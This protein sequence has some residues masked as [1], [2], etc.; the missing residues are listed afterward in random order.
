MMINKKNAVLFISL[1]CLSFSVKAAGQTDIE[2]LVRTGTV[3][4]IKKTLREHSYLIDHTSRDKRDSLLMTAL[5]SGRTRDIIGL[6]LDAGIDP[7]RKNRTGQ[8]ALMY[9]CQFSDDPAVIRDVL[10][11]GTLFNFQRKNR[12]LVRD[13]DGKTAFDYAGSKKAVLEILSQYAGRPVGTGGKNAAAADPT[14]PAAAP[15]PVP[16]P[17]PQ[18][19]GPDAAAVE[20][21][22][23]VPKAVGNTSPSGPEQPD[24]TDHT[25]GISPYQPVYLF[26]PDYSYGTVAPVPDS[27]DTAA[28]DKTDKTVQK[29][30]ADGYTALMAAARKADTGTVKQLLGR[31]ADVN[32]QD[33]DGWTALMYAVRFTESAETVGLLVSGGADTKITNRYGITPLMLASVFSDNPEIIGKLLKN[34]KMTNDEVRSA[35]ILSITAQRPEKLVSVFIGNGMPVNQL[36]PDKTPLMYA[37]ETGTDTHLILLL[38]KAGARTDIRTSDGKTAFDFAAANSNLRRDDVYWLLNRKN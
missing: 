9:A 6:L 1:V 25:E 23:S 15:M 12:I 24:N 26:D 29:E 38:L 5:E 16:S 14:V 33:R 27:I 2:R 22:S 20:T 31:G 10:L 36:Y 21:G 8:T 13:R 37:A 30:D 4:E 11:S 19:R 18:T 7:V 3:D 32:A 17:V 28:A 35:F 34:R